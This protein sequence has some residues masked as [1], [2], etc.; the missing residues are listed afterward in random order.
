MTPT[1][2]WPGWPLCDLWP[3]QCTTLW[4]G[5]LLTKCRDHRTFLRQFDLWMTHLWWGCSENMLLPSFSSMCQSVT[6]RIAG[7]TNKLTKLFLSYWS[8][9]VDPYVTFNSGIA[10][11]FSQGFFPSNLVAMGYYLSNLTSGW[12]LTFG[13]VT[14]KS[15]PWT[16]EAHSLPLYQ[17]SA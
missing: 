13:R 4:S 12:P 14:S 16:L 7:Q 8:T 5:V 11:H 3:Q 9:P 6:K 17:V 2:P 10:L 15:W 1:D